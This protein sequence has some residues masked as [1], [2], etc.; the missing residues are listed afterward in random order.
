MAMPIVRSVQDLRAATSAMRAAGDTLGFVAT[1][2]A[3]HE[4]HVSLVRLAK[5]NTTRCIASLFVN[6]KQ[7]AAH[8]DLSAYP[9]DEA[10]DVAKL[11]AAG[12]DLVFAPKPNEMYADDFA[13][14]ISVG[15]V[16]N[17]LEGLSRPH[18]FGGVATVVAKLFLQV[19]PDMAVFGEKDYQQLLVIRKLVRDMAFP[20]TIIPGPTIR[21]MD[22]L[23]MSSR[24]AYLSA[25]ERATASAMPRALR[26]AISA[27][28][29]R[30]PIKATLARVEAD[31]TQAG[32]ARVDYVALREA[33]TL[34]P[35]AGDTLTGAA[36]ILAAALIGRTRLIDNMAVG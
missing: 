29:H 23:A 3:L 21:E 22:G 27:L 2:G 7:F 26:T 35:V 31:L 28:E 1:M 36:R 34:A 4:G 25:P 33:E 16:S 19:Q 13:T 10:G 11:E 9:R 14:A 5:Q 15:G 32:F 8:E 6:P 24:N 20:I 17:D 12:C 18:F 30:A